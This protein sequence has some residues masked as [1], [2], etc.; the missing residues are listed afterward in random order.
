MKKL[1]YL[2]VVL[3]VSLISSCSNSDLE[4]ESTDIKVA[5]LLE[6]NIIIAQNH[7]NTLKQIQGQL[8]LSRSTSSEIEQKQ[9]IY[10]LFESYVLS[11]DLPQCFLEDD[12]SKKIVEGTKDAVDNI[13]EYFGENGLRDILATIPNSST[14]E[15]LKNNLLLVLE[16]YKSS[17]YIND[18]LLI[19]GVAI[20][21]YSYWSANVQSRSF[22]S[23]LTRIVK[24]DAIS[25][26]TAIEAAGV[27]ALFTG[28]TPPGAAAIAGSAAFG[29]AFEGVIMAFE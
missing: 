3:G 21:S 13:S 26:G 16:N 20:D 22:L 5:Q 18:Y 4:K 25:A 11:N 23:G 1:I 14:K 9:K 19:A 10:D 6:R 17:K 7:S 8:T 24:A 27:A 12:N 28:A 29:S 15:D 2:L